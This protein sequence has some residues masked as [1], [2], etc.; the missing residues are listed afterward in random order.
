MN[1]DSETKADTSALRSVRFIKTET[2]QT[3]ENPT[4]HLMQLTTYIIWDDK[5]I[6]K[7]EKEKKTDK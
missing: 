7:E 4:S 3:G 5:K 2:W 1:V 6:T